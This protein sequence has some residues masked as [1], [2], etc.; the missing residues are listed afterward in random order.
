MIET[1]K[2]SVFY[3]R[4]SSKTIFESIFVVATA[5]LNPLQSPSMIPVPTRTAYMS[6]CE[7]MDGWLF[8]GFATMT[9]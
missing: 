5:T 3:R 2:E 8:A 7:L 9:H 4:W 6:G 1:D